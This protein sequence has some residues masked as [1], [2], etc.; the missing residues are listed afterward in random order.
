[1]HHLSSRLWFPLSSALGLPWAVRAAEL[2][3]L[4]T[5]SLPSLVRW[6]VR[7]LQVPLGWLCCLHWVR[8]WEHGSLCLIV[9]EGHHRYQ[10]SLQSAK[11]ALHYI[12]WWW[13]WIETPCNR[14]RL[15]L[16]RILPQAHLTFCSSS[17]HSFSAQWRFS[18]GGAKEVLV[19]QHLHSS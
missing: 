15:H 6:L 8:R 10:L 18:T 7:L 1:M 9:Q 13:W 5:S 17:C 11:L 14:L 12:R 2:L 16:R 3:S 4:E 19:T